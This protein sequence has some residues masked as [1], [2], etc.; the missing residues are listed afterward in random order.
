MSIFI[1]FFMDFGSLPGPTLTCFCDVS[2]IW[3]A[4]VGD[5][6]QVHVFDDPGDEMLT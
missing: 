5:S 6:F 4:K 3:D 2:V 1:D